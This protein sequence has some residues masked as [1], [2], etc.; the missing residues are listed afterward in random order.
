MEQQVWEIILLFPLKLNIHYLAM[1]LIGERKLIFPE[2]PD[3]NVYSGFV[4]SCHQTGRGPNV[5]GL[6][7]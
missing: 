2:K 4:N 3:A 1:P 5:R 7:S 6:V